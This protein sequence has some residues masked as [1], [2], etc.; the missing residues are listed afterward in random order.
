[1]SMELMRQKRCR[2]EGQHV[3]AHVRGALSHC[4]SEWMTTFKHAST[5][6]NF[7]PLYHATLCQK[8]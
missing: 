5:V 6:H 3:A 4:T 7:C 2:M 8:P 1:M